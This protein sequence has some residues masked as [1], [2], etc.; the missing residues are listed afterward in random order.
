MVFVCGVLV[1]VYVCVSAGWDG[2]SEVSSL[3][4]VHDYNT[5]NEILR[6]ASR[7]PPPPP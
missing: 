5:L 6:C 4:A 1:C 3:A 7:C 2:V